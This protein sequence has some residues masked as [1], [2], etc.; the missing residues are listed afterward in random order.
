VSKISFLSDTVAV[1]CSLTSYTYSTNLSLVAIASS[2]IF[3][4]V[5]IPFLGANK[6]YNITPITV[7][8]NKPTM[9]CYP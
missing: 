6:I 1:I 7:T 8:T 9:C 2:E 5:T 4:L 3:H